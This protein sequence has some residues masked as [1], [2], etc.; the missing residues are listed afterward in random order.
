VDT[1][2]TC[3]GTIFCSP[4]PTAVASSM[5]RIDSG[6]FSDSVADVALL[7]NL[8]IMKAIKVRGPLSLRLIPDCLTL[9]CQMWRQPCD[10][11]AR[12]FVMQVV[13]DVQAALRE[14]GRL[15]EQYQVNGVVDKELIEA[16]TNKI[17]AFRTDDPFIDPKV[18]QFLCAKPA[19]S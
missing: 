10:D 4:I 19:T 16:M 11:H 1:I 17:P 15:P 13:R 7:S 12:R 9:F 6:N 2:P 5:I 18:R 3:H 8:W 14:G